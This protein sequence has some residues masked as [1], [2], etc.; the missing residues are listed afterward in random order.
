[1]AREASAE[2][3]YA[4]FSTFTTALDT[5][6]EHGLPDKIDRS[7]F[8]TQ[9]GATQAVLMSSFRALGAIN[10]NNEVQP[11]LRRL[12]NKSERKAALQEIVDAKYLAVKELG[13]AAT[14]KQFDDVFYEYG[15][16]GATHRK[17]EAFFLKVAEAIGLKLSPYIQGAKSAPT[18]SPTNGTPK[19]ARK[20]RKGTKGDDPDTSPETRLHKSLEHWIAEIPAQGEGWQRRDFDDWLAIFTSMVERLYSIK[21][22]EDKKASA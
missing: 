18:A 5:L 8:S 14:Q 19:P 22:K 12:V 21:P 4:P 15:V 1:M 11:L 10:E 3:A 17:A 13:Q 9:S 20:G 2:V 7:I 16:Q 6:A